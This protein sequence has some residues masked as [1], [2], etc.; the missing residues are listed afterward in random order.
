MNTREDSAGQLIEPLRR[1]IR[2]RIGS[3]HDAEDLLQDLLLKL[4]QQGAAL[5]PGDRRRAWAYRVARNAIIDRHRRRARAAPVAD[6]NEL[7]S[8]VSPPTGYRAEP[9][10]CLQRMLDMLPDAYREPLLLADRDDMP[11][12]EIAARLG[13]SVAGAKSRVQ[14]ARRQL[15]DMVLDCCDI[16][17]DRRG[18][19][20]DYHPRP[21]AV[22]YCG[23]TQRENLHPLDSGNV[24]KE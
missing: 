8:A 20:L 3:F 6:G 5:P 18:G 4:E 22:R 12:H 9:A 1:F 10:R 14:R 11:Q 15:K 19:L 17:F 23:S 13:L 7:A 16:E 2:R 21:Q 24:C